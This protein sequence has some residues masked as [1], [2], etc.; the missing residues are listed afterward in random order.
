MMIMR[1][2]GLAFILATLSGCAESIALGLLLANEA[3]NITT[4]V[5]EMTKGPGGMAM[6]CARPGEQAVLRCTDTLLA[7]GY[8]HVE[9]QDGEWRPLVAD[10]EA[11]P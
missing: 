4:G 2:L 1:A 11:M 6:M 10:L 3:V 5:I 9:F 7:N 8:E